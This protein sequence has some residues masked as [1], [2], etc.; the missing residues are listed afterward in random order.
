MET[1]Q[2]MNSLKIPNFIPGPPGTGKTHKWLKNKYAGFL[3]KYDWDRIVIL[4]HT[5]TAADEIIKAVK[6]VDEETGLPDIPEIADK[7]DT[8]LQDQICTIHS[9]FRGEYV[10]INKYE[11]KDHVA[12]CKDN[13]GMNIVKKTTPWDKHPLYEF[14]SHAHGKGYDLTSEEELEK[15]WALCDRSRYQNY[16]LQG[17]GGLLKL[18]EK[19]DKWR[20]DPEHKRVDF[21]DMI[22]NFRFNA[23]IP[24]DI[25]VLIV[26]EA[27]DCS[28]PQIA[29]LQKAATYAKEFIFIG[30]AD[31]TIH[32]Y[33]GSDP[34]YFYQLAN[35]EQA[36]ANELTEGLRCGQTI[37]KICRNIIA[38]VWEKKGKLS[39]RTWT[40]TDVVGKSYYI[41]GLNQGCKA[42][43][44]LINKILNTDETFLFT[45]RGNP[46][47][48]DI[49]EFLQNN[50]IDYKMV[51]G[52]AHVSRENFSCFKNWKNFM[53]DKVSKQ[54]IKEYWKLMGSKVKVNG[55][56]DVDKLK[57]LIDRDYNVQE[58]IDAGY[59]KPEIKQ[60]ERFSQ[61]LN[62][63]ALSK[64]EKLIPKIPYIN[65]VLTNGMDTTKKPRVQHD[66]IH[67]VKGLTFDNVIVDLSTYYPE[68][69]GFEATRLAYV[70]YSRGK[71]DCWTIGSSAPYSLAKIQNN[72]RE[73]LE[74]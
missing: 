35:T 25:D 26:D 46:T 59:L 58:L 24:T 37:N 17:E 56:G 39:E 7:P 66:T 64:N 28:K 55:Q 53:N 5:N 61:L 36:K 20:D 42:K 71:I 67:K 22:D 62:H 12:F 45:Y 48:K 68:T 69:K 50:G 49:N 41:P 73:I 70:A 19:Y 33:A 9:Y 4:S 60:F 13:S 15:F 31:Q 18:K 47:H 21:V 30:D 10:S 23:A 72:W 52:S 51:S 63:E 43:D 57:P 27:Q 34:E 16:R 38:P 2:E 40:P 1:V 74:L 11:R 54:Q 14:I 65:K 3:K 29:A 6:N 44:V 32:E 8:H